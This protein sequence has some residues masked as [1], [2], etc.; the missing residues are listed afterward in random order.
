MPKPLQFLL[1]VPQ[2]FLSRQPTWTARHPM[3]V[4]HHRKDD[5]ANAKASGHNNQIAVVARQP[6]DHG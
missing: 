2:R 3:K 4:G 1:R 6:L 5:G